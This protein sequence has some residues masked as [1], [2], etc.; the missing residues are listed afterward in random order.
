MDE[1][2][3]Y[4]APNPTIFFNEN[5]TIEISGMCM[6][7][8]PCRHSVIINNNSSKTMDSREI[9]SLLKKHKME[10]PKHFLY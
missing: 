10:V 5:I 4:E 8:Y 7:T 1:I 6:E 3:D 9:A 2:D